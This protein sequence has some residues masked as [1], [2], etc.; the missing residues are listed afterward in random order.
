MADIDVQNGIRVAV[1]PVPIRLSLPFIRSLPIDIRTMLLFPIGMICPVLV[2]VPIVIVLVM[3]VVI[4][5]IVMMVSI[6]AILRGGITVEGNS[7]RC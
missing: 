3:L 6:V 1:P 4:A 5:V 2:V 7:Q